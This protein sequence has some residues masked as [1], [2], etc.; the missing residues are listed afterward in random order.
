[1]NTRESP[2]NPV[3]CYEELRFNILEDHYYSL[4]GR[5][6]LQHQGMVRWCK[7]VNMFALPLSTETRERDRDSLVP[8]RNVK[9]DKTLRNRLIL[10]L[11]DIIITLSTREVTGE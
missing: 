3:R 5:Y 2:I 8:P 1:M 9:P 6:L 7:S 10:V 4:W 11:A